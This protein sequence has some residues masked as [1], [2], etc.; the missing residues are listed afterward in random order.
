MS[1]AQAGFQLQPAQSHSIGNCYES[2]S[3]Q[4]LAVGRGP[5]LFRQ[6]D[7]EV[8]AALDEDRGRVLD[9]DRSPCRLMELSALRT[10]HR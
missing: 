9:H 2:Q 6:H 3:F 4:Q 7:D 8:A 1:R 10:R 5:A